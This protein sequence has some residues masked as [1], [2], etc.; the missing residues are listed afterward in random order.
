MRRYQGVEESFGTQS[1][2]GTLETSRRQGESF[3]EESMYAHK[4]ITLS[5]YKQIR[6]YT[7]IAAD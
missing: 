3:M 6:R 1:R 4:A 7:I 2:K 5:K